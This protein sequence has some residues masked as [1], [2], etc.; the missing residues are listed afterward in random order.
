MILSTH[1]HE[2]QRE[3]MDRSVVICHYDSLAVVEQQ[4]FVPILS[5]Y[6]VRSSVICAP[7]FH[8][9]RPHVIQTPR[10]YSHYDSLAVVEQ[11]MFVPILSVYRFRSSVIC[12]P[13]FHRERP[14][15]G[16]THGA[17][18]RDVDEAWQA[19]HSRASPYLG[20]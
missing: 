13:P 2:K 4:M 18:S 19:Q 15:V 20:I 10:P 17:S 7:P 5:V 16:S 8:R 14:H 11:Q 6:R 1:D 3:A 9:E 12:A